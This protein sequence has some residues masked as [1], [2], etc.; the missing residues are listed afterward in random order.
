[1]KE[2]CNRQPILSMPRCQNHAVAVGGGGG[3]GECM[4]MEPVSGKVL[5]SSV[6]SA[7]IAGVVGLTLKRV[8]AR[9]IILMSRPFWR[10]TSTVRLHYPN[11][12]LHPTNSI[13][14]LELCQHGS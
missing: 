9:S 7:N 11:C 13:P 6:R 10:A 1:M 5:L 4:S 8:P 3:G 14:Q 12:Q 2:V